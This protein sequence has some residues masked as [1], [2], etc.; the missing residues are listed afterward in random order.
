MQGTAKRQITYCCSSS[1]VGTLFRVAIRLFLPPR[2]STYRQPFLQDAAV[3][4]SLLYRVAVHYL[5]PI[6][7]ADLLCILA[8]TVSA[9]KMTGAVGG[10]HVGL[11]TREVQSY[12]VLGK[13]MEV[14]GFQSYIRLYANYF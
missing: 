3:T 13:L 5:L 14:V 9:S 10:K 1:C 4:R 12:L 6:L 2:R 8:L 11:F 7:L